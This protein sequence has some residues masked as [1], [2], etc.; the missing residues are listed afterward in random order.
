[1][2]AS[3]LAKPD[4]IYKDSFMNAL[5]EYQEQGSLLTELQYKRIDNNFQAFVDDL[6]DIAGEHHQNLSPWAERVNETI[7]WLVKDNSFL[8]YI[9]IRHRINWHLERYGGHI[10]FSIR[11]VMRGKGFGKKLLQKA[12][13]L[14]PNL[15][16]DKALITLSPDNHPAIR[17]VEFCGGEFQDE[18]QATDRFPAQKRFWIDFN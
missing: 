1:M 6:N 13:P 5:M 8:G 7:Y 2:P 11:P 4:I 14:I 10:S 17:I 9:K 16:I 18:T 15:G 3:K 12:V